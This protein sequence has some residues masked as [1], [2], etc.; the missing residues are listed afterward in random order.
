MVLPL[1]YLLL[2]QFYLIWK[3]KNFNN[4]GE[5]ALRVLVCLNVAAIKRMEEA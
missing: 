1:L 3:I 4:M 2:Y 5:N